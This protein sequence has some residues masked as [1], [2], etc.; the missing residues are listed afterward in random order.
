QLSALGQVTF[1]L[2]DLPGTLLGW[3]S[4]RDIWI[5]VDAAGWGWSFGSAPG[6]MDLEHAVEHELGHVLGLGHA[7]TGVMEATL[8]PGTRLVPRPLPPPASV[9]TAAGLAVSPAGAFAPAVAVAAQPAAV[10]APVGV[11]TPGTDQPAALPSAVTHTATVEVTL[12]TAA[13]D[14]ASA[15]AGGAVP[16]VAAGQ[17]GVRAGVGGPGPAA[18][19]RLAAA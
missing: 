3:A 13:R 18:A 12:A 9:T 17:R 2:T 14:G 10:P 16:G 15:A 19:P 5:D 11:V 1:H 4:G 6:R 7:D 8:A